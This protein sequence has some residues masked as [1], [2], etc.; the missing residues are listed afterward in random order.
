[1]DQV[2]KAPYQG[3]RPQNMAMNQAYP[4]TLGAVMIIVAAILPVI[5]V[6]PII[7]RGFQYHWLIPHI[8]QDFR[9]AAASQFPIFFI[10]RLQLA[11]NRLFL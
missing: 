10:Q 5:N 2:I 11:L 8:H 7:G 3:H 4:A 1:M 9:H 6:Q